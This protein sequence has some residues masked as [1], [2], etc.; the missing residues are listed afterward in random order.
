MVL[1]AENIPLGTNRLEDFTLSEETKSA[2]SEEQLGEVTG[3]WTI[4]R[5]DSARCVG[6]TKPDLNCLGGLFKPLP[7]DHY[8][9]KE[10]DYP[11]DINKSKY[12]MSCNMRG[13][14]TYT[15]LREMF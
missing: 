5:Y 15:E 8:T 1:I 6:L 9:V 13:F 12:E 4:N 2:I 3:G 7:C 14:A 10:L 11:E